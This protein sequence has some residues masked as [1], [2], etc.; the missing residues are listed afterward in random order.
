MKVPFFTIEFI[1]KEQKKKENKKETGF[2]F[3]ATSRSLVV[4]SEPLMVSFDFGYFFNLIIYIVKDF[5]P[6]VATK[7]SFP[8]G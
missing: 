8:V 2:H 4:E 1:V 3:W 7:L 6:N 5:G